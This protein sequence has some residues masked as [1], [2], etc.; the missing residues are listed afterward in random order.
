M[1][2]AKNNPGRNVQSLSKTRSEWLKRPV[3][4]QFDGSVVSH[5]DPLPDHK[6]RDDMERQTLD[7]GFEHF[8]GPKALRMGVSLYNSYIN[9]E[10]E[11]DVH[12]V[13]MNQPRWSH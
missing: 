2:R 10:V 6:L 4:R 9:E 13:L 8:I 11:F 12:Y 1:D 7:V 3:F 5:S